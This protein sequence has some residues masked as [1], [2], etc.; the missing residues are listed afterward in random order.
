MKEADGKNMVLWGSLSL[1]QSLIKA[2]LVDEFHIQIC[3]TLVGGGR[4]LFPNLDGYANLKLVDI[5]KYDTGVMY[6]HYE[7]GTP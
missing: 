2:N 3:P 5:R 6:L 1:A 4:T 7:P